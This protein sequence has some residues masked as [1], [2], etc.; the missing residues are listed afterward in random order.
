MPKNRIAKVQSA[1][2]KKD[3]DAL[4][5]SNPYSI[6]YLT[7]FLGLAPEDREAYMLVTKKVAHLI[8]SRLYTT[9][10]PN[11]RYL[12]YEK[13]LSHHLVE[14]VGEEKLKTIGF[15]SEDLKV[16]EYERISK[17]IP[18]SILTGVVNLIGSI[19]EIKDTQEIENIRKACELSDRCL[20]DI[21]KSIKVGQTEGEIAFAIEMWTQRRGYEHA[22]YP[23]VAVDKNSA[24]PHHNSKGS[25]ARVKKGSL[26]LIDMGIKYR[27]YHSD[28]TRIFIASK[29]SAKIQTVYD[30]L[31]EAQSKTVER[32]KSGLRAEQVDRDCR[33]IVEGYGLPTY[34]HVTGH[35]VG[36]E[37]HEGPHITRHSKDT[38]EEGNV[39]TIEPGV[40]FENEF[41]MRIEDTIHVTK[42]GYEVL[43]KYPKKLQ[44][45]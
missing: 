7:G 16:A 45:I 10:Y 14:L 30:Q 11:T 9:S 17:I 25:A 24:V 8:A 44:V 31:L 41:G 39:I 32:L 29:P 28:I 37:I 38:I 2:Q 40:Y 21:S 12:S 42:N 6:Y 4:F 13:R 19:R 34:P 5:L 36:L 18:N 20:S 33:S 35:G 27:N 43:T 3:L 15:E 26:I 23:I 1:L 22:F